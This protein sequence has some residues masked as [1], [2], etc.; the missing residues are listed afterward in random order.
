[1]L[2][3]QVEGA[4]Q[5]TSASQSLGFKDH[6]LES[7]EWQPAATLVSYCPTRSSELEVIATTKH[8]DRL[9]EIH[10]ISASEDATPLRF[11]TIIVQGDS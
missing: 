1:M 4:L 8:S 2:H 3:K 5:R 10:C 7:S 6:V 9:A 11:L